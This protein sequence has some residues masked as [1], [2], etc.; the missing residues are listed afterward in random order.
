MTLVV[1]L[2]SLVMISSVGVPDQLI[3]HAAAAA[4]DP[5]Q[6]VEGRRVPD[7]KTVK[8]AEESAPK[9]TRQKP[10][11][12]KAGQAEVAVPEPGQLAEAGTL[13]VLVGQVQGAALDKVTVETLT[14]ETA[15]KLGGVGVAARLVRAD[16]GTSPGKVRAAFSYAD[17]RNAYGGSFASRLQVMRLPACAVQVPRPK[18]C[19]MHPTVVPSTND[20]K[21]GTLTAEV[22]AAP[23]GAKETPVT[24]SAPSKD[25]K[26]DAAKAANERLAAQLAA[27]SVYVLMAGLTGPDGNW[28]A[29]DLKPSGTW[30]AGTSG[31]GFDY[32]VPLPEPPS[33]A[34]NGPDLSLQYNASSV[35][36][37][38]DWTNNQS[39]VVGAGWDLSTGF[40]ERRYQRCKVWTQYHPTN[41]DLIWYA[42]AV[43][44]G[45]ALCWEAPD[46]HAAG[47]DR[48]QSELVLS[49]GGR[50]AQ[51]VK[52]TAGVWKTVPDFGWKIEQVAGGADGNAYW[53]V[54]DRDG[55][56]WRFG[57]NKDAQ[58]QVPYIGEELNEP[59]ADRY[60]ANFIPP[61]CTGVWRWNL[62]QEVDRNENV[63][64]YSYYRD[65]NYFCLP[66]CTDEVYA[67]LPYDRG[68][69]LSSVTWGHNSQVAGSVPT[70]RMTF[71]TG[72][73]TGDD[74]P[75]DLQCA[76]A[77][78]CANNAISFFATRRLASVQT[79]SRTSGSA[80]WDPVD[81]LDL[82]HSWVYQRT[83][84]GLPWDAAM[85][86]DTVQQSGLAASPQV[87]LPPLDFDA[88]MLAGRMDYVSNSDWQDQLSW[89][90]VPR[91]AAIKNGMG[92]RTEVTYG[93]ADPCGGAKGRDGTNYMSDQVGDCYQVDMGSEPESDFETWARFY[94]QLATKVV[95][96]DMVGGS[97]DMVHSY[98]FLGSPHWANPVQIA[99]PNLAPA[100][101]SWRGYGQVRTIKGSG[102]DP[103]GY[104]VSTRTFLRGT[105]GTV[106]DFDGT[107]V[108]D[109]S[110]LQGQVLQEQTWQMTALSP[111]AYTEIAS[112]RWEYTLTSTGTGWAGQNPAYVVQ[113]RERSREKVTGGSWR[114]TD[115]KTVANADGL[116]K[117]INDYGQDGV[118]TDN[119]CTSITYARNADAGQWLI[120]FPSV[121]EKRSGDDCAT[122]T[123]VG[124]T[125]TL[126]DQGTDPA[127][128]KPSDGNP[129]EVRAHANAS[130][131]STSKATFD[132]YGRTL[133]ATDPLGKTTTTTYTPAT[134]WP[135]G[136]IAVKDPLGY[137]T[138]T[139]ISHTLGEPTK[140]VDANNKTT[141]LDYDG[142]GRATALWKPGQP[143]SGGTPSATVAYA[144]AW[145]GWLGQP[146]A[147]IKT[148]AKQLLTGTGSGAKWMTSHSYEDGLGRPRESQTASPSPAGG[149][150]VVAT[151][152]NA[153][154]LT[155]A[156]GEPAHNSAEP[157]SGLLN[158]APAGLPQWTKSV[159]DGLERVTASIAYHE[160]TELRRT[161][162]AYPGADRTEVTPPV[163]G[164]TA[165]VTDA[166]DRVVK[167]EE[168]SDA[169]SHADTLYGYDL[170]DNLTKM[171]D[172]NGNVRTYTY[173]WLD[174]RTA[175]ADPDAGASSYGYDAAGR[176]IWAIDGKNQKVSTV[177]DDLGRRTGQWAGEPN[178]G[179]RLAAWTYDTVA[180]GH[181]GAAT[182]Y[183]GGQ[184]YTQTVTAYDGDYRPTATTITIPANE[185]GLG[186]DYAF[187]SAYDAAGNL[188][189]QGMPAAGGLLAEKLTHSYTDLGL[190]KATTSDLGGFTYVKDTTFTATGKLE[191][192]LLG[193]NGQIKRVLERDATTEWLSRVTTQT[194]ANTSTPDT[195]QDDRYSYNL[196]GNITRVL[197]ADS[198]IAGQ[199]DGQSECFSYDG[200]LRLKTAYTTTA[201]SC[202]G[203]G[204]VLGLDPYSHAY[205]YD[206]VGNLTTLTDNGQSATYT[207]PA[208]GATAVRP[209]AV[210]SIARPG[211]TDT[212]AYDNK[213]QLTARTVGGKQGT[214]IWDQ[215][216]QLTQA[217]IDGQQT[218][219]IYDAAGERLIRRDPDGSTTLYLG[220][221][222]LRLASGAV[223]GKRYYSSA[224]SEP[225]AMRDANGVTWLLAGKHGST[226]LAV[227]DTT[228]TVSRERY[229]PFGQRR[230]G[231]DLPF[232]D[233]GFLG[234]TEDASTGLTYLGARFYDPAI[235]RFI[236]TDPELDLRTPEWAN[237]YSYAG[238]NPVEQ[239]DPDGRR[240]DTGNRESDANF[241]ETHNPNG[242]KKTKAE[243]KIHKQRQRAYAKQKRE[244]EAWKKREAERSRYH[245]RKSYIKKED[246][247]AFRWLMSTAGGGLTDKFPMMSFNAKRGYGNQ[248]HR[249]GKFKLPSDCNSFVP[250]TKVL[251]K[252]GTL[253]AIEDIRIGDA[254]IATDP[255]AGT[256]STKAVTALLGNEGGKNLVELTIQTGDGGD[257]RANEGG[258]GVSTVTSTYQHPFWVPD[259]R[260]WVDAGD[261]RP[262]MWLRTSAGTHVQVTA[263]KKWSATQRVHN[264]TVADLHTYFVAAGTTLVLVHNAE[265]CS[266]VALGYRAHG[267]RKFAEDLRSKHFLDESAD[268][269]RAPTQKAIADGDIPLHVNMKGFSGGFEDMAK[270][271]LNRGGVAPHATEEEMGWIARAVKNHRR[272]WSSIKFYDAEGRVVDIPEPD[273]SS[274][275]RLRDF[276]F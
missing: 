11:W 35:D 248:R 131:V 89:R 21:A 84:Q 38:G 76:Q 32:D 140:T 180:K 19:V 25:R 41:S 263:V 163:G 216:G 63:T 91:I 276:P 107:A 118:A 166:L 209:N 205:A 52:T 208:A 238:N 230:G 192:R 244:I 235:A 226:Q 75:T 47:V 86:L 153:R 98:E 150:I 223:T 267:T 200:L 18:T 62:D 265:P 80:A 269:W 51:I 212:Y 54:T 172:A 48:T 83:D 241:A 161:S 127:T 215:L 46:E 253:K 176:Q 37:Q 249:S 117:T 101:S 27:G 87:T 239:S 207:Y 184:P 120:D 270:R 234:K 3:Q 34:G 202:T 133:T 39:S 214:F 252:D 114:Y 82:T 160:G 78:G 126:Y 201:S 274:F 177:Y 273:W 255:E 189:E 222:E 199:T 128:N 56:V 103:A 165:T 220:S 40:I 245:N 197:D 187:T 181:P 49:A 13:P 240:V 143:R 157:G 30:Q 2:A 8:G 169:T 272:S 90:M 196:A 262:G 85:W 188:R 217:T 23:V 182:S 243:K 124:K 59:C 92:G 94:K 211:G 137:T 224:D 251:M 256:T 24:P 149:R 213:G 60:W 168:W 147:P 7:K 106:T 232:T 97:P 154:G 183:T 142:I 104:S 141:E 116:P 264:L 68:G 275:G 122:G 119:S 129:T 155:E 190:T 33:A 237:A 61:T 50:S 221:M 204:D 260:E 73:R 125:V 152:Y 203:T 159:Y 229:L 195:V 132:D 26:A 77:A 22:E 110:L 247:E 156:V 210:T 170:N 271:G 266:G 130:T 100:G 96:R 105:G 111:R 138:T 31:G 99:E 45:S 242:A 228:G 67:M 173:D 162:T 4:P 16:G 135:T 115:E 121:V 194:K 146:T 17:F 179:T 123:L 236:S 14:P 108:T 158:P 186:R 6:S 95:E 10:V 134:G 185:G 72:A 178:T 164:K 109:A 174:R 93:Q 225:V 136:G 193:G 1:S 254:V 246:I 57:Y 5:E 102:S 139:S 227:N 65:V 113:T 9:V 42:E 250:G 233:R 171:T 258:R 15:A 218:G 144:I 74:V 29:T 69:F 55:Q 81:R 88:V 43:E 53:K 191:S 145:D 79:E 198:A 36:G 58:W 257:K 206:K 12:P 112:T 219:M 261:L 20:L 44:N 259:L 70:A 148:T 28:G 231:D 66:S 64:D 71:T 167:V 175:A 151:T 268:T